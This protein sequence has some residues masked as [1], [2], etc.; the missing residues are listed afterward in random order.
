MT[1]ITEED[2]NM[3]ESARRKLIEAIRKVMEADYSDDV[4][5]DRLVSFIEANVPDPEVIN[6]MAVETND[7]TPE[8]VL[9]RALAYRPIALPGP[10]E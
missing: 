2:S 10:S 3:D 7:L 5:M 4:E 8:G 1:V 9:E 6:Y